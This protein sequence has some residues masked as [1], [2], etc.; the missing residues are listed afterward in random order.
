MNFQDDPSSVDEKFK[1]LTESSAVQAYSILST[2]IK[3]KLNNASWLFGRIKAEQ[4]IASTPG[5]D[6]ENSSFLD[7][8]LMIKIWGYFRKQ[9]TC[10]RF[11]TSYTCVFWLADYKYDHK[12]WRK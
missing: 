12:N 2:A 7:Y 6:E 8:V 10:G 3:C 9:D 5:I 11:E 1:C 4:S